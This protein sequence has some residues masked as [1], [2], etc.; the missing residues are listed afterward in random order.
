MREK[1]NNL[2]PYLDH[3]NF[4]IYY[5]IIPYYSIKDLK[6]GKYDNRKL[7]KIAAYLAIIFLNLFRFV[8]IVLKDKHPNISKY[9]FIFFEDQP[10]HEYVFI[11]I[12]FFFLTPT[13]LCNCFYIKINNA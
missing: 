11:T 2:N 8:G 3:I 12:I 4:F 5:N 10:N 1:Y 6:E 13:I 7:V 9:F